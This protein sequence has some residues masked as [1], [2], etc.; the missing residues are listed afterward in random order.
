MIEKRKRKR[1]MRRVRDDRFT[2][3]F[4]SRSS[5]RVDL[6]VCLA[7]REQEKR[8]RKR[9]GEERS[10]RKGMLECETGNEKGN[11]KIEKK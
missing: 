3:V 6:V 5:S 7:Q 10:E 8:E 2:L 1:E 11:R 4:S 9:N